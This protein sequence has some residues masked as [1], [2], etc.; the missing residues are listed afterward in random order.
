MP[1]DR[2]ETL[3][4]FQECETISFPQGT[5]RGGTGIGLK[6]R[7]LITGASGFAGGHLVEALLART[8]VEL[9]GVS[10]HGS[11]PATW[12]HLADRCPLSRCDLNDAE[13]VHAILATWTPE[14]IVHI[15]GYAHVGLSFR[16][17]GA[18]WAGNLGATRSLLEAIQSWGGSPRVLFVGSGLVY[19]EPDQ[20]GEAC[21]ERGLLRPGSPYAASKAAADLLCYQCWRSAGLD[22]VRVRPFNHIGPGQSAEFAVAHFA[23]QLV[24]IERGKRPPLLETGDLSP[25]RDLT[26]VRDIVRG[27]LLLL[28]RGRAGDVYNLGS[29]TACSM[30]HVLDRLRS[31]AGA[32]VEVRCRM[33]LL[34]DAETTVLRAD[35]SKA[36]RELGWSPHFSLEQTLSDTLDQWRRMP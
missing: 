36:R 28:E 29:G 25:L 3:T 8:G 9:L 2:M 11:W 22:I 34:R 23:R 17:P 24:E 20:P 35:A 32:R 33:D 27:Y 14:Q 1:G 13:A 30:Q 10:R 21:D 16:E 18:A 5:M 19:G 4:N 15:A 31:R 26:D 12:R 7:I 6:M